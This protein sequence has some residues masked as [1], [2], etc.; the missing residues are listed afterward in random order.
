MVAMHLPI[1]RIHKTFW[2]NPKR[3]VAGFHVW[4]SWGPSVQVPKKI[5]W[6]IGFQEVFLQWRVV[7]P[8]WKF[9]IFVYF[10]FPETWSSVERMSRQN[11]KCR[12]VSVHRFWFN[13]PTSVFE[14]WRSNT[15]LRSQVTHYLLTYLLACLLT[16]LPTYLLH[17]AESLL[18]S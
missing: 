3:Y 2:P 13:D 5:D 10:L 17:G 1:T 12:Q 16:Y 6:L 15:C 18:R 14:P 11:W 4:W 7:P 8:C 9:S